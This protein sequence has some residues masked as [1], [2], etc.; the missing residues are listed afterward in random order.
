MGWNV[1]M[2]EEDLIDMGVHWRN[3]LVGFFVGIKPNCHSVKYHLSRAWK[4]QEGLDVETM[5]KGF[6]FFRF[7]FFEDS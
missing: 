3:S 2:P 5:G 7:N 6:F 4:M 1:D